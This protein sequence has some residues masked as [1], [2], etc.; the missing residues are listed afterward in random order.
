MKETESKFVIKVGG[1]YFSG[2]YEDMNDT[3]YSTQIV[4]AVKFDS[5]EELDE[6]VEKFSIQ[7]YAVGVSG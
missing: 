4:N 2:Y 7:G 6:A 1:L 5:L 3:V